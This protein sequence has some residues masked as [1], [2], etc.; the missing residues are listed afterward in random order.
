[1]RIL[2]KDAEFAAGLDLALLGTIAAVVGMYVRS[3]STVPV[4]ASADVSE[5]AL[6]K[7]TAAIPSAVGTLLLLAGAAATVGGPLVLWFGWPL[8]RKLSERERRYP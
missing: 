5:V 6:L 3:L 8:Y 2:P 4:E 7:L 1:M